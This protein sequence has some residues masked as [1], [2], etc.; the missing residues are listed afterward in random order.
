MYCL[1]TPHLKSIEGNVT[2]KNDFILNIYHEPTNQCANQLTSC[3][4]Q[5]IGEIVKHLTN[6]FLF[7]TDNLITNSYLLQTIPIL[8]FIPN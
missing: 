6:L 2:Y 3:D 4:C 7:Q 8:V 5:M 1:I